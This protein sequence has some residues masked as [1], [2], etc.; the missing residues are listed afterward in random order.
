MTQYHVTIKGELIDWHQEGFFADTPHELKKVWIGFLLAQMNDN[1]LF[2]IDE[3][4]IKLN[5]ELIGKTQEPNE[6]GHEGCNIYEIEMKFKIDISKYRYNRIYQHGF[7][8]SFI[9]VIGLDD[10][11]SEW[12]RLHLKNTTYKNNVIKYN[13]HERVFDYDEMVEK[14][15]YISNPIVQ[16]RL[17]NRVIKDS[18]QVIFS[19]FDGN[20]FIGASILKIEITPSIKPFYLNWEN[21]PLENLKV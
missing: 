6:W 3:R 18:L 14:Y 1:W 2:D 12:A 16:I 5:I 19:D 13:L 21:D 8:S 17:L 4:D 15:P 7:E 20:D 11:F 9:Q 10:D